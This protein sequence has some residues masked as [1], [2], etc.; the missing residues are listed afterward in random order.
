MYSVVIKRNEMVSTEWEKVK[1]EI[2]IIGF[3]QKA[4]GIWERIDKT[5]AERDMTHAGTQIWLKKRGYDMN[6]LI[7]E[8]FPNE[9]NLKTKGVS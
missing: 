5:Q 6:K 7:I 3:E 9:D 2:K 8:S 4:S 1:K